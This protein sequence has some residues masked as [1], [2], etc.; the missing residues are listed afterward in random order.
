MKVAINITISE[1]ND[2]CPIKDEWVQIFN[3]NGDRMSKGDV[4][5]LTSW[6]MRQLVTGLEYRDFHDW[7]LKQN[8]CV[9]SVLEMGEP[10]EEN[11]K[12]WQEKVLANPFYSLEVRER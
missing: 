3:F 2:P 12:I 8:E 6:F 4:E 11:K 5:A 9:A 7:P 1:S 10:T